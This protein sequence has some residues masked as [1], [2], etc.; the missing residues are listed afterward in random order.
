[1]NPVLIIAA[2]V[3]AVVLSGLAYYIRQRR[4]SGATSEEIKGYAVV[5]GFLM[6]LFVLMVLGGAWVLWYFMT[7]FTASIEEPFEDYASAAGLAIPLLAILAGIF[8]GRKAYK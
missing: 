2:V 6:S 7:E 1:M 8:A 5:F 4:Q 3:L